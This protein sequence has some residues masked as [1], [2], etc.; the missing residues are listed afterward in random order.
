MVVLHTKI[1]D[2]P[3]EIQDMLQDFGDIIVDDLPDELPP[4][5]SIS[6][7]LDFIPGASLPNKAAYRMSP[8]DHEEIRKQLQELL[9]KGMIRESMS[10]CAVP[11][12]LAPKKG[13][14]WRMCTDSRAINKITIRYRFPLP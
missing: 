8:K 7:C 5:R 3:E 2:L 10:P 11:T 4:K 14:E 9:D 12:V 6:H 13:G 1:T